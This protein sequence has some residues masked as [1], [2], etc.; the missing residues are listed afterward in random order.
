M[1][2]AGLDRPH[3]GG[4]GW[5][6]Q[7]VDPRSA[8]AARRTQSGGIGWETA[9]RYLPHDLRHTYATLALRHGVPVEVVSK[10]LGHGSPAITLTVYRHVLDDELRATVVD[11]F[12][13]PPAAGQYAPALLN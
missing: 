12:P 7:C 13:T 9:A 5:A 11:L 1:R 4:A 3:T 8:R 2:G 6:R 10:N